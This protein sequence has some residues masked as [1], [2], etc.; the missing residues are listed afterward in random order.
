MAKD[1]ADRA[2]TMMLERVDVREAI[3]GLTDERIA[4][5]I[6]K[7]DAA[8]EAVLNKLMRPSVT[9]LAQDV[10]EIVAADYGLPADY[11][12]SSAGGKI[13]SSE[14][15]YASQVTNYML[16][17]GASLARFPAELSVPTFPKRPVMAITNDVSPG[18]AWCFDGQR[19]NLTIKLARRVAPRSFSVDHVPA[20]ATF[21]IESAPRRFRVFTIP[22]TPSRGETL[23]ADFEYVVGA[24]V[25]HVQ[26]FAAELAEEAAAVRAV[27]VEIS[28]NH[29]NPEFT[30]LYRFRVHA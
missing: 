2:L 4:A 10:I 27:R 22:D 12:L 14:P 1:E 28:E 9:D 26:T 8:Q 25:R 13:I 5:V 17:V 24:G 7:A 3:Q 23:V 6:A 15:S 21:S 30:C 16:E 20:S 18:N 11:A 29:G 19:A